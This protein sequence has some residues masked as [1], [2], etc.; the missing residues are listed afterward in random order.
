MAELGKKLESYTSAP[1]FLENPAR[2]DMRQADRNAS[3][4]DIT[5]YIYQSLIDFQGKWELSDRT[6]WIITMPNARY[7]SVGDAVKN[8]STGEF[9]T[10]A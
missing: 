8:N 6:E 3:I 1:Y 7:L 9:Y 2:S 4:L 5:I 10:I